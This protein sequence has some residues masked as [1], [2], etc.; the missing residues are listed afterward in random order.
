MKYIQLS[1]TELDIMQILWKEGNGLSRPEILARLEGKDWNPNSIH[2][3]LNSM[4]KKEVLTVGGMARCGKVYGRV[5][6]PAFTQQEFLAKRTEEITPGLSS[7][8]RLLGVVAALTELE[9][10]DAETIDELEQLLAARKKELD[11]L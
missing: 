3:V 1:D 11:N 7:K 8:E 2:Q 4:M 9:G 10:I 5:Y 6:W